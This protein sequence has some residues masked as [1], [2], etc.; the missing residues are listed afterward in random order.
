MSGRNPPAW[1]YELW[2][3]MDV[4][5]KWREAEKGELEDAYD[6][7]DHYARRHPTGKYADEC[8]QLCQQI[9]PHLPSEFGDDDNGF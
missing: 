9:K 6:T 7:M 4:A 8:R 5:R 1:L 2:Y 3:A